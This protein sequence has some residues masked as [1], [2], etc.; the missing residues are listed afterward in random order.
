MSTF[1][2]SLVS[3]Q[4]LPNV[5]F[6]KEMENVDNYLFITT[7]YIEEKGRRNMIIDTCSEI[8]ES[9]CYTIEV[10]E[11]S[12]EDLDN[13]LK[14]FIDKETTD[15]DL[16]ILN[17]TGGTKIMSIGA[18]NFF[19]KHNSKIYYIPF[20]KN[21]YRQIFPEIK[22]REFEINYHI[23]LSDYIKAHGIKIESSSS[24]IS[25]DIEI[26]KNIFRLFDNDEIMDYF[27]LLIILREQAGKKWF[28]K[29]R[30]QPVNSFEDLPK[31]LNKIEL[32]KDE[33]DKYDIIYLTGGWFEEYLYYYFS[34]YIDDEKI[35]LNYNI[36]LQR[37]P[38][39]FDVM[40]VND[41]K[42][43]IIEAKTNMKRMGDGGP[44]TIVNEVIYKSSS[45]NTE[46]GLSAQSYIFTLDK[47]LFKHK[48]YK[49][50]ETRAK[51]MGIQIYGPD[52][53]NSENIDG[54]INK[55]LNI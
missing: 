15:E 20:G 8:N 6:I 14:N 55:I 44:S 50:F 48:S 25:K 22:H 18:Y 10:L 53:L 52:E 19:Q 38:N 5:L 45:L 33:I 32:N 13:K 24:D 21:V 4:T 28:K 41:N 12:L 49:G 39:E 37:V 34:T 26:S 36:K 31:F 17:L 43:F 1:L 2:V 27:E 29:K 40:F 7:K 42:I 47:D 35:G 54:T 46:F 16:F 51:L 30:K 9:N 23:S 11:D 3:Q